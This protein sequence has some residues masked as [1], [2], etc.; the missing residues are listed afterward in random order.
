M[1]TFVEDETLFSFIK[2]G[3]KIRS[4]K[5][6]MNILNQRNWGDESHKVHFE[7]GI[8]LGFGTFN[9]MISLPPARVIKLL[10]FIGFSRS[11]EVGLRELETGY[12]LHH[13]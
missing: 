12:R 11:K 1:L 4:Y 9:L 10:E 8:R 3:L 5:E 13:S 7:C 6:C 2:A